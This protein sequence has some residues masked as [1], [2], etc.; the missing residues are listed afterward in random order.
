[1]VEYI[2]TIQ[3]ATDN[4]INLYKQQLTLDEETNL[5]YSNCI[6]KKVNQ[7]EHIKYYQLSKVYHHHDQYIE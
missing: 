7:S 5:N 6:R 4:C 1:M 3:M 2:K